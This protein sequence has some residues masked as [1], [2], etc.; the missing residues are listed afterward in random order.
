MHDA[1][2]VAEMRRLYYGEHWRI[3][4][5]A[6]HL[7]IH[8]DAI[9]RAVNRP[10]GPAAP[11]PPRPRALDPFLAWLQQTLQT[12]PRLPAT[13]LH[14]MLSER[15]YRGGVVQ[16]RRQARR[17][18]PPVQHEAFLRLQCL[19]GEAGQVDWADFGYV[20]VGRAKRR[21]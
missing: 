5:I 11:R 17:L 4:T 18:R 20:Q 19:P 10:V 15:G 6:A 12:Y 13:V 3:G 14:R 2:T 16:V 8:P 1:A 9:R 7:Q 21:L